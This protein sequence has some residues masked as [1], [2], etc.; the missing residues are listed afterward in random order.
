MTHRWLA[1][2]AVTLAA[3]AAFADR[4]VTG[5]M[6]DD[7]T[8]LPVIGALVTVGSGEAATDD[9]GQFRVDGVAFGRVDVVVIADG[10]RAYFGSARIGAVL[11]IRLEAAG[12]SSEV[13]RVSGRPPGGPPLHLDT[14][15]VR[16]QPGA[17]NDVLRALQSLPG[18]A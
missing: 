10:Y 18:V 12:A 13:I 7:A 4:A 15:A 5:S 1:F 2:A 16:T 11:A 6:V 3:P 14:A 9:Q 8:G 17:G